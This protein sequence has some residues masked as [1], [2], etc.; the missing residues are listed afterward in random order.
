MQG[1][2]AGAGAGERRVLSHFGQ[3]P[4]LQRRWPHTHAH[5]HNGSKQT[6]FANF[7]AI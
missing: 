2:G 3:G 7:V 4:P 6:R 5:S 1:A